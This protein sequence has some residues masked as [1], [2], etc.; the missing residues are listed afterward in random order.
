[1]AEILFNDRSK[2]LLAMV[3]QPP[4]QINCR[5]SVILRDFNADMNQITFD[6]QQLGSFIFASSLYL[7]P[8][9]STHLKNSKKLKEF[10]QRGIA[11]L[12]AH[13]LIFIRYGI[14]LQLHHRLVVCRDWSGFDA[15]SFQFDF[16][17]NMDEKIKI[18]GTK[19]LNIFNAHVPLKLRYFKNLSAP[20]L[21]DEICLVMR[22]RDLA[23]RTWRRHKNDV[24]YD[25]YKTLRNKAQY[26]VR[27]LSH[28]PEELN[29]FFGHNAEYVDC[30][31]RGSL[32]EMLA[33]DFDDRSFHW[34][35][36]VPRDM[37]RM[38][39]RAKSNAHLF[40]FSLMNGVFPVKWK[41]ALV[42]PIFKV[43]NPILV[44]HYRPISILPISS[45]ALEQI[46]CAQIRI[47]LEG[48]GLYDLCQ[49]AY[50]NNYSTQT[51]LIRMLDKL[52][53]KADHRMVTVSV[54]FDFSK[55]FDRSLYFSESVLTWMHSYLTD[56][57]SSPSLVRVEV[58]QSSVLGP[59][60]FTI[61]LA[62]FSRVIKHCKYNF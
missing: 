48:F 29:A 17:N 13:D 7:V 8:F 62:D 57:T 14:K 47:Y 1:M 53:H 12:S 56:T 50:R 38:I 49:S 30:M 24:F 23:R 40:N 16:S 37:V 11:F 31:E 55:A 36:V 25:R 28:S 20:W 9:M 42:C 58:P 4:T 45:K 6:S 39:S 21:T 19:F 32:G 54:F 15:A 52:R 5:H 3:Y 59:L 61:Y 44:Q 43:K 34:N 33:G 10:G 46:V 35:Y 60:L 41:S 26:L 51:Y 22:N 27:I 18:F 2:L